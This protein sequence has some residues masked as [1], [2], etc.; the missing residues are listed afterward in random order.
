MGTVLHI[1]GNNY[2][3]FEYGSGSET[4]ILAP[5]NGRPAADLLELA[6]GVAAEGIRVIT[7]NYRTIGASTGPVEGLTLHDYARD[8]WRVADA[9]N[10]KRLHL[11]G[12]AYGNRVMRAA[13]MAHPDRVKSII[14]YAAGGEVPV[15]KEVA[16]M[17]KRYT[18]PNITK[19]EWLQLQAALMFSPVHA[20]NAIKSAERGSYP[21]LAQLQAQAVQAIPLE[22]W[23]QGGMAPMLV[24]TGLDDVFAVPQNAYSLAEKRANTRL[25][26]LPNCGHNMIFE[27]PE[28]LV[29]LTVDHIRRNSAN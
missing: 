9:L 11:G 2:E 25:V 16:E 17:Y 5:G 26:G 6:E 14:L 22:E 20:H 15:S 8:V 29:A 28:D 13:S 7:F 21:Q 27:V 12:K 19:D 3:V 10:I 4:L 23:W 1:D 24:I 18:D